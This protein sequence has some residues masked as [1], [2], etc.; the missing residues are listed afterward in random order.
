MYHL[1]WNSSQRLVNSTVDV[2][3]F[4]YPHVITKCTLLESY[5]QNKVQL[6][7]RVT[8]LTTSETCKTNKSDFKQK[9]P[10]YLMVALLNVSF[11]RKYEEIL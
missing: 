2:A 11:L 9:N 5:E 3:R 1:R 10:S 6:P 8:E 7:F 4:L